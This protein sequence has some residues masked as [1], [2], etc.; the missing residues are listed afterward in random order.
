MKQVERSRKTT[1]SAVDDLQRI[2]KKFSRTFGDFHLREFEGDSFKINFIK[3]QIVK[4]GFDEA[5]GEIKNEDGSAVDDLER[6]SEGFR[7]F[8]LNF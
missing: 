2:F 7:G 4:E 6:I 5:G 3:L 8:S 1:A